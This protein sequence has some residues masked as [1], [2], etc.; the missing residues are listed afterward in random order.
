MNLLTLASQAEFNAVTHR[1]KDQDCQGTCDWD[2]K[3]AK[4]RSA[5]QKSA[6][7]LGVVFTISILEVP[8][9]GEYYHAWCGECSDGINDDLW[10]CSDWVFSHAEKRHGIK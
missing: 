8:I 4:A 3:F 6:L 2:R 7:N 10:V 5:A 9:N 1:E